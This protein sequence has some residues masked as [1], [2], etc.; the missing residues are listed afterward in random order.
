MS[1]LSTTTVR[2]IVLGGLAAVTVAALSGCSSSSAPS[3]SGST[4]GSAAMSS[5]GS[6]SGTGGVTAKNGQV[7]IMTTDQLKFMPST[8]T[9]KVGTLKVKLVNNGS[10]PH[11]LDVPSMHAKSQTVDGNPGSTST[12]LTLHFTKPGR[13]PFECTYHASSGMRGMF[14]V[15]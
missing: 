13:Y 5:M 8:I 1:A 11:N 7:T 6:S 9:T 3:S 4:A 10:Y 14:I 2:S 15:K 12:M